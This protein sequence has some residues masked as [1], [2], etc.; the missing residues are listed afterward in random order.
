M[1][2]AQLQ[3]I[4]TYFTKQVREGKIIAYKKVE[5][6]GKEIE[7]PLSIAAFDSACQYTILP[8]TQQDPL[9]LE[10]KTID[11]ISK[12]PI[13]KIR[14]LTDMVFNT[15]TKKMEAHITELDFLAG[16]VTSENILL[17]YK[18]RFYIPF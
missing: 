11:K 6:D 10:E 13:N 12:S 9:T 14:V 5:S 15:K 4:L 8:F 2:S 17:G 18:L 7:V 1:D 3:S 16:V